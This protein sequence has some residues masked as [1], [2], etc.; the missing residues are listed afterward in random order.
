MRNS[1]PKI[2][3]ILF[4]VCVTA[5]PTGLYLCYSDSMVLS[6]HIKRT[7]FPHTTGIV[8]KSDI[9]GSERAYH[10]EIIYQY[11]VGS[12]IYTDSSNLNS[13]MFGNKR[14]QYDVAKVTTEEYPVG[15]K[16]EVLYNPND[17][18]DSDL[19]IAPAWNVYGQIGFGMTLIILSLF[20]LL[21]PRKKSWV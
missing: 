8:I 6:S 18:S 16:L 3:T 4:L 19:H 11:T 12:V 14:K 9:V 7:K 17:P 10:P 21:L 13:P 20:G 5:L 1:I 2:N 15:K